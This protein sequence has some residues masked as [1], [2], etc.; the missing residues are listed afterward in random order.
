MREI[1]PPSSKA[2]FSPHSSWK[3][4]AREAGEVG[5]AS[6]LVDPKDARWDLD[7]GSVL[8]MACG[9]WCVVVATKAHIVSDMAGRIVLL[10]WT[11]W[12]RPSTWF[13]GGTTWLLMSCHG[14]PG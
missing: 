1:G 4:S 3:S 5:G 2:G 9:G 14:R 6:F 8:A 10:E 11:P 7:R 12:H 13:N